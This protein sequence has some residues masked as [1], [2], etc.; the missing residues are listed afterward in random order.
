MNSRLSILA[1]A[2]L[3]VVASACGSDSAVRSTGSESTDVVVTTTP[4]E[5]TPDI[6]VTTGSE[7]TVTV[8]PPETES[9]VDP[10]GTRAPETPE[11]I[12][13]IA[14][15]VDIQYY[16]A[17][18]N[19]TFELDGETWYPLHF[20]EQ[21][22]IDP[23]DYEVAESITEPSGLVRVPPPGSGD[24]VGTLFVFEDGL[25]RFVSDSSAIDLWMTTEE[26][27]YEFEC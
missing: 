22:A 13:L 10:V 8:G 27:V 5:S 20:E 21:Q 4:R 19:E 2:A 15:I 18:G 25:G 11:L 12:G 17:C 23:T 16:G 3:V 9:T 14:T 26:Q 6:V 24:D 1:L 7:P